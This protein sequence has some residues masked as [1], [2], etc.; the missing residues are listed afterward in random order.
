[1]GI[2]E[3]GSKL[4]REDMAKLWST[5]DILGRDEKEI[6]VWHHRLNHCSLKFVLRLSNTGIINRKLSSIRT[7]PVCC[8]FIWKVLQ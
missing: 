5:K 7:P 1:M 6:L 3:L 8:L 4:T 2:Y